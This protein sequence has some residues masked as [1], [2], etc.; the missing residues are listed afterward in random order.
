MSIAEWLDGDGYPTE[1]AL[2]RIAKWDYTDARGCL[3]FIKSLWCY[4]AY[5]TMENGEYCFV[6]GGWSGN[7]AL[8]AALESNAVLWAS[9]WLSSHRGGKYCFEI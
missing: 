5:A 3:D 8:I 6:T 1:A 2:D 4:P 9:Y 7:E